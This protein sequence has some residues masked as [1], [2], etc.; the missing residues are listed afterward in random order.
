MAELAWILG[1]IGGASAI[2]EFDSQYFLPKLTSDPSSFGA[3]AEK[4]FCRHTT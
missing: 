2:L 1:I 4:P 3:A